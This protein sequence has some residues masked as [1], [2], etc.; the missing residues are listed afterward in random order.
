LQFQ[1]TLDPATHADQDTVTALLNVFPPVVRPDVSVTVQLTESAAGGP[2]LISLAA[3]VPALMWMGK[4]VL[5]PPLDEVGDWLRD[6]VRQLRSRG[7][8]APQSITLRLE[9]ESGPLTL[10]GMPISLLEASHQRSLTPTE[11][12]FKAVPVAIL[13]DA[14]RVMLS[15]NVEGERW[16][17]TIWPTD[18]G[19][20]HEYL[21]YDLKTGRCEKK[22]L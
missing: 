10:I 14:D 7:K 5:G 12:L 9:L 11:H 18:M 22:H 16:I 6:M 2:A 21:V 15:W 19:S 17:C 13:R 4:K 20:T 3:A 1:L 8:I